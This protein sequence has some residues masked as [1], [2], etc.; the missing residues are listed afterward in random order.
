LDKKSHT[1]IISKYGGNEC[2]S[3]DKYVIEE[4]KEKRTLPSF[5]FVVANGEGFTQQMRNKPYYEI[6]MVGSS[7][8]TRIL[9]VEGRWWGSKWNLAGATLLGGGAQSF[10][11][12]AEP[13]LAPPL[14][15]LL[16]GRK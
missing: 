10:G 4:K 3:Q 7:G 9:T 14:V 12:G 13:H 15:T 11:D 8:V 5:I 16:V 1:E 6:R 2:V